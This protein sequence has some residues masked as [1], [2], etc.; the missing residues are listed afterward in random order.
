[1]AGVPVMP[2][3]TH[4]MASVLSGT[5]VVASVLSGRLRTSGRRELLGSLRGSQ[6]V[7]FV[8]IHCATRYSVTEM[9]AFIPPP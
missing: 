5:Y 6:L 7:M 4:L 1:M 9:V 8:V 3:R 2:T